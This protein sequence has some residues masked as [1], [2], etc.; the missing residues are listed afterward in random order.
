VDG[1]IFVVYAVI[2]KTWP[3]QTGVEFNAVLGLVAF[4]G[5]AALGA[6]KDVNGVGVWSM[7][8]IK[9]SV[10]T[11]SAL[12][13]ALVVLIAK[14]SRLHGGCEFGP[15]TIIASTLDLFFLSTFPDNAFIYRHS[16]PSFPR[17]CGLDFSRSTLFT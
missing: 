4:A 2:D 14:S 12:D 16:L 17:P 15:L 1:L 8:R 6:Y 9:F 11:A 7:K 13:L 5:L 3:Q 10:A